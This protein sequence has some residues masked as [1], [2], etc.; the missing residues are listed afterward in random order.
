[1]PVAG[2]HEVE[3]E[4]A[5]AAAAEQRPQARVGAL[6]RLGGDEAGEG[7]ALQVAG[8]DA[9]ERR[10]GA[11]GA[12]H[13]ERLVEL[14]ERRR[15]RVELVALEAVLTGPGESGH[16]GGNAGA[17]RDL[18]QRGARSGAR[19]RGPPA[20]PA[21]RPARPAAGPGEAAARR[22][23]GPLGARQ[24][25]EHLGHRLL[26]IAVVH[27]AEADGPRRLDVRLEVVD[28]EALLGREAE[29]LAV[30]R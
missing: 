30:R 23:S 14:H 18:R 10:G 17:R 26:R 24:R 7:R 2:P 27:R 11:V 15:Q 6:A 3:V 13:D 16:G 25:G 9:H 5:G 1:M 20:G 4:R 22:G 29:P 8:G 21:A 19:T 12:A 28:E